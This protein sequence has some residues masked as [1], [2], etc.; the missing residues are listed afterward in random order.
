[1]L[2]SRRVSPAATPDPP[3]GTLRLRDD[4]AVLFV[5]RNWQPEPGYTSRLAE[6]LLGRSVL[7][8]VGSTTMAAAERARRRLRTAWKVGD[9][10][11]AGRIAPAVV[12]TF[13]DRI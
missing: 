12:Q 7:E 5:G 1:V 6:E 10:A 4:T 13:R 11:A 2:V 9:M 8:I 3:S